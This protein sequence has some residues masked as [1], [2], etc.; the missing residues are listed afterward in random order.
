MPAFL[1]ISLICSFCFLS[2]DIRNVSGIGLRISC[3]ICISSD[4]CLDA[5]SYEGSRLIPPKGDDVDEGCA[6]QTSRSRMC[7][8]NLALPDVHNIFFS[9]EQSDEMKKKKY[10]LQYKLGF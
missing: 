7:I 6:F 10:D 1:I 3:W 4:V 2:C 9:L 5:V 8:S